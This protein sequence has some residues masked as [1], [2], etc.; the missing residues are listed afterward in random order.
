MVT[1]IGHRVSISLTI[2]D[3]MDRF[4]HKTARRKL[5]SLVNRDSLDTIWKSA[6]GNFRPSLN[7]NEVTEDIIDRWSDSVELLVRHE[8]EH[9]FMKAK[10]SFFGDLGYS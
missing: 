3:I 2:G 8:I 1:S 7:R 9:E 10:P 5:L 4:P 6:Y